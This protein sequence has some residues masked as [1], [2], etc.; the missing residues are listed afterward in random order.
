MSKKKLQGYEAAHSGAWNDYLIQESPCT[1]FLETST[2]YFACF[3]WYARTKN[4]N[5][6]HFVDLLGPDQKN[7]H[8]PNWFNGKYIFETGTSK[9]YHVLFTILQ[10]FTVTWP[11]LKIIYY[12]RIWSSRYFHEHDFLPWEFLLVKKL[13]IE[14]TKTTFIILLLKVVYKVGLVFSNSNFLINKIYQANKLS[15]V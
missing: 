1:I 2:T 8:L 7:G 9:L 15:V 11:F 6:W 13:E 3:I 14:K 10:T 5:Y 4:I 12:S